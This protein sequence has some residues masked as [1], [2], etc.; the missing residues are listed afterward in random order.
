MSSYAFTCPPPM[1]FLVLFDVEVLSFDSLFRVIWK[2]VSLNAKSH[3]P[4]QD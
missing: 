3:L 1:T 2:E 4:V